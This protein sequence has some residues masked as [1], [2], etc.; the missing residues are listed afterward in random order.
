MREEGER[1][2]GR[3][4]GVREDDRCNQRANEDRV[5][6]RGGGRAKKK[7]GRA[8]GADRPEGRNLDEYVRRRGMGASRRLEVWYRNPLDTSIR[9]KRW[10][11]EH[12][13]IVGISHGAKST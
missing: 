6:G 11:S 1:R 2:Q 7:D 3:W 12:S 4:G 5:D 9:M 8:K 10:K 13:P